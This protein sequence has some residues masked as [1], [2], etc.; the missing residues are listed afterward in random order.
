MPSDG[1]SITWR[2]SLYI[3]V[4]HTG[5]QNMEKMDAAGSRNN[6]NIKY[7]T[8]PAQSPDLNKL[9]ICFFYSLQRAA[10]ALCLSPNL[11]K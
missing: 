4:Q 1:S 6:W 11:G 8:Q 9:D 2:M 5:K 10:D 7:V 3:F